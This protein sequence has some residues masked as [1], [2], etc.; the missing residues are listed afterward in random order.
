ML[1]LSS[2]E[3]IGGL[4]VMLFTVIPES[5][6]EK[7]TESR[8]FHCLLIFPLG[9]GRKRGELAGYSFALIPVA[10]RDILARARVQ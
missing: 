3:H 10:K 1:L 5:S 9:L 4:A 6:P 2:W 8:I 7:S